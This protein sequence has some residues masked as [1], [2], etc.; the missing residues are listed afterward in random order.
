MNNPRPSVFARAGEWLLRREALRAARGRMPPARAGSARAVNQARLLVEVARRV[1]EPVESLPVGSR[2]AVLRGLYGEAVYW[3]LMADDA[4]A[5]ASVSTDLAD[6]ADLDRAWAAAAPDRLV[7]AAGDEAKLALARAVLVGRSSRDALDTTDDE[8]ACCR[9]F[10]EALLWDLDAPTRAIERVHVQRWTRIV[11]V[12]AMVVLAGVGARTL[13][14][15]ANL[16]A[17]KVFK[18]STTYVDCT[19]PNRCGDI[20]FHTLHQESPW[21]DFDL[22]AVKSVH[23]VEVTNRSDC[24]AERAIPLIVEVSLDDKTWIQVARR[25]V[26]FSTWKADFPKHKAR[27]VRL[28]VPRATSL[29]FDDVAI[30]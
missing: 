11:V 30:R 14:R 23:R 19:P 24:C 9:G 10:A 8:A 22:G 13:L 12:A 28:R 26:D 3:A 6:L 17:A 18:T 27:Y 16:A 20:F 29:H 4:A 21:I 25:D 2:P 1:A 15:G 7:K 5:D